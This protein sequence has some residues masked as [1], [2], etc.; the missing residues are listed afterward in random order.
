MKGR[1]LV[2]IVIISCIVGTLIAM[3]FLQVTM[4]KLDAEKLIEETSY[5]LPIVKSLYTI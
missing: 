1:T 5:Y 4:N 3:I 2:L